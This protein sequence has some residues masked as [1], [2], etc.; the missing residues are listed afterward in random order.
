MSF[1]SSLVGGIVGAE[2]DHL[3]GSYI[4]QHGGLS[5]LVQKFETQGMGN[6]VQ[7]W[8]GNGPNQSI[9]AD[10]LH[11]VLGSDTVTQLAAKFG[12]N[13]QD[14]MQKLSQ[15]L[16]DAVNKMTPDGVIPKS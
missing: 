1:L 10:Q 6:I 5:A 15:V 9:S 2:L 13:P 11:Q 14:V 7:S 16:P 3:V 4:Q 12:L 8:I